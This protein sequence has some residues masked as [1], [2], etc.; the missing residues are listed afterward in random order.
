MAFRLLSYKI[1]GGGAGVRR[2]VRASPHLPAPA[3]TN[4]A[5]PKRQDADVFLV[6]NVVRNNV[7][8]RGLLCRNR[9]PC[10]PPPVDAVPFN[11]NARVNTVPRIAAFDL[12]LR[13]E[14]C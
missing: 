14:L 5:G 9:P 2:G 1:T 6:G 7:N 3:P 4:R 13:T 8:T 12:H 10:P 11:K